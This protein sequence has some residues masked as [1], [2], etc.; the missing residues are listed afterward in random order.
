MFPKIITGLTLASSAAS[1]LFTNI[2]GGVY[3][4]DESFLATMRALL[5]RRVPKNESV[6]MGY[7]A[8]VYSDAQIRGM[9]PDHFVSYLLQ[10]DFGSFRGK[11]NLLIHSFNGTKDG[12]AAGFD[13]VRRGWTEALAGYRSLDDLSA[14]I[15]KE[16]EFE[17][18]VFV[19]E[20]NLQT[21]I[22]TENMSAVRWHLLESLV[23][24]Y[25]PWYFGPTPL[26]AEEL[27]LVKSL[28]KRSSQDYEAKI[29]EF[30]Q[31]FDFRSQFIQEQLSGF[32][33]W[34]D[35]SKLDA[36]RQDI[37][38]T[39]RTIRDLETRFSDC[40]QRM[41]NLRIKEMGLLGKIRN[42]GG[43]ESNELVEF[44]LLN[45][46][47]HLMNASGCA[48]EF[49]V[50][51]TLSNF[52][53]DA[54]DSL[55]ENKYSHFYLD[56]DS[57]REIASATMTE[58]RIKR[59]LT[60]IFLKETAKI[61][62]YAAFQLDFST[63]YCQIITRNSSVK[64]ATKDYT[65]NPHIQYYNC[66]G[67]NEKAIRESM[68]NNDYVGAVA[69]CIQATKSVNV[70]EGLTCGK[71]ILDLF[72]KDAGEVI[73]M[74]DGSTKTPMDAVQWFEEQDAMKKQEEHDE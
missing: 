60:E 69:A 18:R 68:V 14:W 53:P 37:D 29:E 57:G 73:E 13:A 27:V 48:V 20:E 32:E 12:N 70:L 31:R 38:S 6:A 42:G 71:M 55:L 66:L 58:Q 8:S 44:F 15:K 51:T 47:L 35:R 7:R 72:S 39:S 61:R 1:Q 16:F 24:R 21:I 56:I 11:C 45:K 2:T 22:F 43:D 34:L 41:E 49:V 52:D 74:P 25:F 36:V 64:S 10:S 23:T 9:A 30:A 40:Y 59:L 63:G 54:A 4:Q 26:D 65:P 5:Y 46:T 33:T 50:K 67:G 19:N 28:T 17:A 3:Q 62:L